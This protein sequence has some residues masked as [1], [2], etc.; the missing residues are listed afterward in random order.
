MAKDI[1]HNI[2]KEALIFDAQTVT[3]VSWKE[4]QNFA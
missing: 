4:L 1:Y 2:V 3:I